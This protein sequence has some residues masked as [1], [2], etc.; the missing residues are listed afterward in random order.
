MGERKQTPPL[1]AGTLFPRACTVCT[2]PKSA[3]GFRAD[4]SGRKRRRCID[5]ENKANRPH[6][7]SWKK[8]NRER[9]RAKTKEWR[10]D[11]K[12]LLREYARA[13]REERPTYNRKIIDRMQA[14]TRPGAHRFGNE[15]TGPELEMAARDDLTAVQIAKMIGRTVSA[16]YTKR[17]AIHKADPRTIAKLGY[18]PEKNDGL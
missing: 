13:W 18:D 4:P 3:D 16:V 10:E 12:P 7:E 1:P 17:A 5:C 8:R 9:Y 6:V 14:E 15:W 11:N 2:L